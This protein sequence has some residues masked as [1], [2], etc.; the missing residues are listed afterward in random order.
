MSLVGRFFRTIA[1]PGSGFGSEVF[2]VIGLSLGFF[3]QVSIGFVTQRNAA[4][5][6]QKIERFVIVV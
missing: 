1:F 3:G 4:A 5:G 2:R 6:S